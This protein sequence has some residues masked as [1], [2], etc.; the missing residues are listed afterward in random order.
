MNLQ[1]IT[2]SNKSYI[3]QN[4]NIPNTNKVNDTD[5]N[6]IK[7]VINSNNIELN[8]SLFYESGDEIEIGGSA[9]P[10]LYVLPGYVS[11]GTQVL[12]TTFI[13]PKRLDNISS[14]TIDS[15]L[16]EARS[17]SG[18]LN[19]QGGY[20]EYVAKTG[21]TISAWVSSPN[22]I[23]ISLTKSTAYTNVTNNTPVVLDG[24]IKVTLS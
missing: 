1:D 10:G 9:I 15:L 12:L 8:S 13:T 22:S 19:S 14:V 2:Y 18:Y 7:S 17:N 20:I 4:A 11:G 3:N 16:V 5:M 24:Y 23:S 21:Y 6:E